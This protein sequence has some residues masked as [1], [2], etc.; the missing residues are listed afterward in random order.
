[1]TEHPPPPPAL[2]T[3]QTI[4]EN[5]RELGVRPG[6]VLV[7]HASLRKVGWVVG[8]PQAVVQALLDVLGPDG[9]L[10]VPT[11]TSDNSDPAGW[12]Y[13]P[14]PEEWWET[15]RRQT[16]GFDPARTPSRLMGALAETVRAWPGAFRSS[17]PQTS[18][19]ALGP[20]A[21]EITRGHPLDCCL[22]EASPIGRI[23]AMDGDVLLIGIGHDSNTSLHLGE[24]RSRTAP[25]VKCSA[26]V[27]RPDGSG[28]RW[29]SWRD[30]DVD[31]SDFGK[32][33]ADLDATDVVRTG[34]IGA[35]T[36]RLMNQRAAVDF[37]TTW[38]TA[39]RSG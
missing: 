33:G 2:Q 21:D 31:A 34:S 12:R 37:A 38:L 25:V 24:Y 4:R 19:A 23:N 29:A 16:P 5:L 26:S 7:V 8:G 10:V 30:R 17:H 6:S 27:L 13:P 18:F 3:R 20:R 22:G 1:M 28:S 9:T 36:G 39:N 11:H 14:V 15:I 32:L 35:A